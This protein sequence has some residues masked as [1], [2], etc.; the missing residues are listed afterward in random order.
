[1]EVPNWF[2]EDNVF[3]LFL[4]S[5]ALVLAVCINTLKRAA[6]A[7]LTKYR[8]RTHECICLALGFLGLL[9]LGYSLI[10][11]YRLEQ[12]IISI[13]SNK[14]NPKTGAVRIVHIS[15]LHCDG[16]IRTETELPL[17]ISALHPDLIVFTGDSANNKAGLTDFRRCIGA[18]AKIAPTYAVHGNHDSRRGFYW[19][20]YGKTGVQVL[21]CTNATITIRGSKIWLAGAAA[22]NEACLQS[23]LFCAPT[24]SLRILLYHYPVAVKEAMAAHIDLFCCGHTHGGQVR[25]PFYGALITNSALGKNYEAGLYYDHGTATYVSRGIGMIGL[26]VRFLCRP[27][28]T[29]IDIFPAKPTADK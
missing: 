22:G 8:F 4:G 28:L 25:L 1:M 10:E 27:E 18:I 21:N 12:S 17:H 2:I 23:T 9:C 29:A 15:D 24:D 14:L 3:I 11:P 19:D 26:P 20:I 5:V 16:I 6:A 13:N 7:G